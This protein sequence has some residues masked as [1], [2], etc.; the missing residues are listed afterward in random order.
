VNRPLTRELADRLEEAVADVEVF[1]SSRQVEL[2]HEF[3]RNIVGS[4]GATIKPLLEDL[5]RD[6]RQKIGAEVVDRPLLLFQI[7]P[8]SR[9]EDTPRDVS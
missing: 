5:R 3:A 9:A 8:N 1:G 6:L 2:V 4:G 7:D